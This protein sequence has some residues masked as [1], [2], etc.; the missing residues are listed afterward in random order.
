MGRVINTAIAPVTAPTLI[1][2][3]IQ[4]TMKDINAS[5]EWGKTQATNG[6]SALWNPSTSTLTQNYVNS[7]APVNATLSN[8]AAGYT[9]LGGQFG[10][11]A[12][13]GAVTDYCLF[14]FQVPAGLT[15]SITDVTI[16]TVNTGAAVA[17]TPTVLTWGLQTNATAVSLATAGSNRMHVGIQSLPIGAVIGATTNQI[18][19]DFMTPL[20]VSSGRFVCII[21]RMPIATAT[22]SQV[23]QGHVT[24]NGYFE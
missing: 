17:T 18:Q 2:G 11:V 20:V 7:T 19:K 24:I 23:I 12:V 8:T 3:S 15:L 4:V 13:A 22:A 14:G 5:V 1:I 10:F 16:D 21:L 9:T 6:N